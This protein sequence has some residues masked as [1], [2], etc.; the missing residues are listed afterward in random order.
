MLNM[1]LHTSL[2]YLTVHSE[3][4]LFVHMLGNILHLGTLLK[5]LGPMHGTSA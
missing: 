3:A 2:I 5:C 4:G 1:V